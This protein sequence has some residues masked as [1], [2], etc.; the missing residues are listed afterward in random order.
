MYA[1]CM[2]VRGFA[3]GTICDLER[4]KLDIV[5]NELIEVIEECD[6]HSLDD[7][8]QAYGDDNRQV[9]QSYIDWLLANEYAFKT[10]TPERFP[11]LEIEY[12]RP[13][14]ITNALIDVN[15]H[16]NHDF[17]SISKSLD[18]LGCKDIQ[19]RLFDYLN[20]TSLLEI[21][22]A[23]DETGIKSVE[24]LCQ[25]S[26]EISENEIQRI[27]QSFPRVYLLV[28]HSSP[29]LKEIPG[30]SDSLSTMGNIL[31]TTQKIVS[32][33]HC[34]LIRPSQFSI[35]TETYLESKNFNSCLNQKISIDVDGVIKNCPSMR[36]GYGSISEISLE[37]V[38]TLPEFQRIWH[39][40]KDQIKVCR[41][42]EFRYICTDCRAYA[43][44]DSPTGKPS[45][46]NY[47]PYTATWS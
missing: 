11:K 42:C 24:L 20:I 14:V 34:G 25:Y 44:G 17:S 7:V 1:A 47:D 33:D 22:S 6:Q 43:E 31:Y 46:C 5:S 23:F 8:F 26:D 37:E 30:R 12:Q 9:L 19:V 40:N 15:K 16:S 32:E 45:K 18:A 29:F 28:V 39:I 10:T 27:C 13:E 21:V 41:D 4:N 35:N 2:P 3:R 38:A 36:F